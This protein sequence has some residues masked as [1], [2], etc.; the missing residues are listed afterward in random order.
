M[1]EAGLLTSRPIDTLPQE[2]Q[3]RRLRVVLDNI[4]DWVIYKK[5]NK[6]K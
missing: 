1:T 2:E 5:S 4:A 6:L 3:A